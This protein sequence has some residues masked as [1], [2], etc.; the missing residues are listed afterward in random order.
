MSDDKDRPFNYNYYVEM[1]EKKYFASVDKKDMGAV[2]DC[3]NKDAVF[4][5]QSAFDVNE[6]RDQGIRKMFEEYFKNFKWGV[7]KDFTHLV[8]PERQCG[9]SQFLV[10]VEDHDGN[11]TYMSNCNVHFFKNGK[12]QR[13]FVYMSGGNNTLG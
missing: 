12:F 7:H 10:E 8:D 2:L 1:V 5:I 4:T 6:G 3:F 13:V 9:A 11:K